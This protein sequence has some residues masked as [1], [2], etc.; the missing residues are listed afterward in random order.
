[1]VDNFKFCKHCAYLKT[2][3]RQMDQLVV[4]V[5]GNVSGEEICITSLTS[6]TVNTGNFNFLA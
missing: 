5:L 2:L 4:P 1:M 3:E 6:I